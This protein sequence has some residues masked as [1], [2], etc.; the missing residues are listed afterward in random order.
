M[1]CLDEWT[2]MNGMIKYVKNIERTQSY[3]SE[4]IPH[5]LT[6]LKIPREIASGTE[7]CHGV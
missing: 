3:K 7:E 6:F 1:Q 5:R 2:E 4:L